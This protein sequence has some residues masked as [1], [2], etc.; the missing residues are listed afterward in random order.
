MSES[1]DA[2]GAHGI[3]NPELERARKMQH[4]L[5]TWLSKHVANLTPKLMGC[6]KL[7]Q[8]VRLT[9]IS[10]LSLTLF[11]NFD[12]A[13]SC[14]QFDEAIAPK[15]LC[16]NVS[17]LVGGVNMFHPH[18]VFFDTM[19]NEVILDIKVLAAVVKHRV[20][21]QLDGGLIVDL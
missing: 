5:E 3:H 8:C 11:L 1:H 20:A 19:P 16:K 6:N 2:L 9:N 14:A 21:T 13:K 15:W 4:N 17:Q 10:P 18:S 7:N 12:E